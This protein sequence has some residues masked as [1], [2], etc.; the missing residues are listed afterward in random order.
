MPDGQMSMVIRIS[1]LA[2]A[3]VLPPV[4]ELLLCAACCA[5][6]MVYCDTLA[7]YYN[8]KK[9]ML[10]RPCDFRVQTSYHHEIRICLVFCSTVCQSEAVKPQNQPLLL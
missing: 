5:S 10:C 6:C 2:A 1:Q 9:I 4:E 3:A 7:V 8:F